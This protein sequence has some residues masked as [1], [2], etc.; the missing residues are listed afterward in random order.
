MVK[1][2]VLLLVRVLVLVLLLLV[3][4]I[5]CV[6]LGHIISTIS[7]V[8]ADVGTHAI[9]ERI[10]IEFI[11]TT[12]PHIALRVPHPVH[13]LPFRKVHAHVH[14]WIHAIHIHSEARKDSL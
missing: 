14:P 1:V 5:I 4:E 12:I 8:R 2:L 9:S 11:W 3:V 7:S 13:P 6:W 10:C